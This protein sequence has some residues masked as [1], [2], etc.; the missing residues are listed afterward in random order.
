MVI[1]L[2]QD[3]LIVVIDSQASYSLLDSRL[4]VILFQAVEQICTYLGKLFHDAIAALGLDDL[5]VYVVHGRRMRGAQQLLYAPVYAD[6]AGTRS[7]A[8]PSFGF[9]AGVSH[10]DHG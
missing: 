7:F 6:T 4:Q 8:R 3:L 2:L 10:V 5:R 9:L 1:V